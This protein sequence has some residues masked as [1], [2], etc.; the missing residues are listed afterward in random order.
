MQNHPGDP[1]GA[2]THDS[3]ARNTALET[4]PGGSDS[5]RTVRY[6]G[7][8]DIATSQ[9]DPSRTDRAEKPVVARQPHSCAECE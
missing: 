5:A 3:D 8:T 6:R 7:D 4:L 9:D 2:G 1:P